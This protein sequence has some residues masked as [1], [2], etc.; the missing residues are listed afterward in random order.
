MQSKTNGLIFAEICSNARTACAA[1][2]ISLFGLAP[3]AH[4]QSLSDALQQ[5]TFQGMIGAIHF[6][7]ANSGHSPKST[8]SFAIGGHLIAH[9]G[10]FDG[11]SVGLGGYTAQSLGLYSKNNAGD[12]SHYDSELTGSH[13]GIQSFRQAYLQYQTPK[14]EIRFGRQLIQTPYANQDYYTFNPRAFMGV[15]GV[16]NVL[17]N[18]SNKV[19]AGALS[20]DG[21]PAAFSIFMT[22]M[23]DYESRYSSSFTAANRYSGTKP[24]NGFIAIGARYHGS[25]GSTQLT[26]QAWYYD[27]Y[28]YAQMVYGQVNFVQ[29]LSNGQAIFG[30]VQALT[31][32]NSAGNAANIQ[33]FTGNNASSINAHIYGAKL[34]YSF[35]DGSIA[36]VGNYVPTEYNSFH[37][38]GLLHP[39]NDLT[40]TSFT[41][42]MQTGLS[43]LG[44]GYAY[45]VTTHYDF[46][47]KKLKVGVAY[48]RYLARYGFGGDAANYTYTG[49]YGF[50]SSSYVPNQ[51]L[52][53][54]DANASYDLS[55]VLKGLS[56]AEDTDI[57]EA[58]NRSGYTHYNNPYFSSRFYLEYNF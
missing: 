25:I 17:G 5:T 18:G 29:P 40:G 35:G 26:A 43:N 56:V 38:G 37:H 10:S 49:A 1:G 16:V 51:Q 14:V 28:Q 55:S 54:L 11:F 57:A 30:A 32:G 42:T 33:A 52:W 19:D 15:A 34:G 27:F 47:N 36:L 50:S 7:Y 39:Y 12:R 24:A 31:E 41:D 8:H 6:D 13:Y 48:I 58:E 22:R 45:G 20:L 4:A 21:N 2:V 44:P 3:L 23:F 46:L 9:T 53:A